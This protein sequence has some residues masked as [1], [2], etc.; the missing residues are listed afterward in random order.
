MNEMRFFDLHVHTK[1]SSCCKQDYNLI[2]AYYKARDRGYAGIGIS[3]HC[4]YKSYRKPAF[5]L[6]EQKDLI[7]KNKLNDKILLG[8]EIS[9]IN[10]KGDLGVN[11]EYLKMLDFYIISE[12]CHLS[13]P[14]SEFFRI[15]NKFKNWIQNYGS[16]KIEKIHGFIDYMG[17]LMINAIKR[18]PKTILAHIWRFI[19]NRGFYTSYTYSLTEKI[20][21]SLQENEV[22]LE[23]HSSMAHLLMLSK[24][25]SEEIYEKITNNVHFS[26][27]EDIIPP[28][29]YI[30]EIFKI[31]KK[32]DIFYS[33]GSDAHR[34]EDIGKIGKIKDAKSLPNLLKIIGISERKIIDQSFFVK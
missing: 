32:Y 18:N 8:L 28:K 23:I 21:E 4:N 11:L 7:N 29:E 6:R 3:D 34:I 2:D 5:F 12:H 15:K 19:R 26:L 20:M 31:S 10:H 30:E 14:F 27:K 1:Y 24:Q 16:K 25:E 17:E 22:A 13:K 9:I 33:F